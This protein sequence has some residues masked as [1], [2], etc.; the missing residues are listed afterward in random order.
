M[1]APCLRP[2][3]TAS[4]ETPC[5]RPAPRFHLVRFQPRLC[6]GPPALFGQLK[7]LSE[8]GVAPTNSPATNKA[9]LQQAIDWAAPRACAAPTTAQR[10]SGSW[11]P[12]PAEAAGGAVESACR[13]RQ[14]RV[15]RAGQF[16]TSTG[17][18]NLCALQE[19]SHNHLWEELW[20]TPSSHGV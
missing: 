19:A 3:E 12:Q 7:D 14:C 16:W 8:F 18:R 6:R 4:H 17:L 1:P 9:A 10:K 5:L 15:K 20:T 2:L 13:Q 11:W